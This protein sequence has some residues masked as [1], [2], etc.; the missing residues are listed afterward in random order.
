MKTV[1]ARELIQKLEQ[2][3][4]DTEVFIEYVIGNGVQA[5]VLQHVHIADEIAILQ[6]HTRDASSEVSTSE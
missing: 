6:A 1:T 5:F 2:A 4:P 3:N